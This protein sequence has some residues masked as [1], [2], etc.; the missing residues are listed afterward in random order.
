MKRLTLRLSQVLSCQSSPDSAEL[1]IST[2]T[3][4]QSQIPWVQRK[5]QST[6]T[7]FSS[8][9]VSVPSPC[10]TSEPPLQPGS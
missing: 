7:C 3:Q 4:S 5:S 2:S 10:Y 6:L 8:V 9:P 1:I